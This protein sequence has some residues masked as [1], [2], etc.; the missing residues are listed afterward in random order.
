M[1]YFSPSRGRYLGYRHSHHTISSRHY[2]YPLVLRTRRDE[3]IEKKDWRCF[4]LGS[5]VEWGVFFY[6][7]EM[8]WALEGGLRECIYIVFFFSASLCCTQSINCLFFLG[9]V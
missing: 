1:L 5:D 8:D 7:D 6:E 4:L 3:V 9:L 2:S